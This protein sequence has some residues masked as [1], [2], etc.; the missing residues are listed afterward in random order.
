[1]VYAW[2]I[3][4]AFLAALLEIGVGTAGVAVPVFLATA[5]CLFVV[6]G[7]R[8][9][10]LPLGL[11]G[12]VLDVAVCRAAFLSPLL[13]LPT[14]AC[15][16]WWRQRGD[17]HNR[18]LQAGPGF[19]LGVLWVWAAVLLENLPKQ[20]GGHALLLHS[21]LLSAKAGLAGALA[22]PAVVAFHDAAAAQM[23]F[24]VYRRIQQMEGRDYGV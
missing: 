4:L 8:S 3:V 11:V 22:L 14:A 15:A 2:G 10:L 23:G 1:M 12:V 21:L 13:L 9:L 20:P 24:P 16:A 18:V 6:A 5:F 19:A 17:C 7:W